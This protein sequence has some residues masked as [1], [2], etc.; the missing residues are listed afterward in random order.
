MQEH[1]GDE[2]VEFFTVTDLIRQF[3]TPGG[4]TGVKGL[5]CE[6][7]NVQYCQSASPSAAAFVGAALGVAG[8][9]VE[10][11]CFGGLTRDFA[12]VVTVT[13]TVEAE[14]RGASW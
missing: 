11:S 4:D 3:D 5:Q 12:I 6:D 13:S 2:T 14:R 1:G 8:D 10:T 9:A 7:G